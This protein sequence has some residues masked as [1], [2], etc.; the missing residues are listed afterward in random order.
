M[1]SGVVQDV[2]RFDITILAVEYSG[3]GEEEL[4]HVFAVTLAN[5]LAE[6]ERLNEAFNEFADE[7]A[8]PVGARRSG[9]VVFDELVNNVINYAFDDDAEHRIEVRVEL[10]DQRFVITISDDG[11]PFNPFQTDQPDTALS[12]DERGIGGLGVHLVRYMTDEVSYN[13]RTDRNVVTLVKYLKP[14]GERRN[15]GRGEQPMNVTTQ[16]I[17]SVTV[18]RIEGNLDTNTSPEA[19]EHFD[20]LLEKGASKILVD[21]EKVDYISSAGLR[22]LLGTVKGLTAAGGSLRIS[23]LNESVHEVFEISGFST[24]LAVF[25]T[26]AEALNGF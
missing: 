14:K 20:G 18:V 15:I 10:N 2:L 24:I 8:I 4:R 13:R 25:A 9:N 17:D 16:V 11:S 12:L 23:G 5:R 1:V 26:E 6:I 22:V 3:G 21:C 19:Q 7:H